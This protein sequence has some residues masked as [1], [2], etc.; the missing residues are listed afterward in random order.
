MQSSI[1]KIQ[2]IHCPSLYGWYMIKKAEYE[3]RGYE[4]CEKTLVHVTGASN[5]SSILRSNLNWRRVNRHKFGKGISFADDAAYANQY[6]A[7]SIGL[8]RAII[9]A[10]VLIGKCFLGNSWT[11]LPPYGCDTTTGNRHVFVK[12]YDDEFLPKYV[13]YYTSPPIVIRRRFNRFRF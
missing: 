1:S 10:D 13:V 8:D 5:I 9:I 3:S 4:D 6:A 11:D 12:F 7:M 2:K